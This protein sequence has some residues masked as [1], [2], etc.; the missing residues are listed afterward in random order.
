AFVKRCAV[1][2]KKD[3]KVFLF[4]MDQA[5]DATS[6]GPVAPGA[7]FVR[8]LSFEEGSKV[9]IDSAP[10]NLS[11]DSEEQVIRWKIPA[12]QPRGSEVS[13]IFHITDPNGEE[14]FHIEKIVIP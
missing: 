3:K 9:R 6:T 1:I 2:A 8:K 14:S 10:A 5:A 4:P 13:V 7:D 11:Y 12:E